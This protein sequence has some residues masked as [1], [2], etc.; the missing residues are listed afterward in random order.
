MSRIPKYICE[1][2]NFRHDLDLSSSFLLFIES[3]VNNCM[4][5]I[6]CRTRKNYPCLVFV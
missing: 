5:D 3:F 4:E 1:I 2:Y 6:S